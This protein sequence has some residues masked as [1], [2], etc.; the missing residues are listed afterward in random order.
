MCAFTVTSD[1]TPLYNCVSWALHCNDRVIWP[2]E[3][4]QWGWPPAVQRNETPQAFR[5]FFELMDFHVCQGSAFEQGFEKIAIYAK[6]G[7]VQHV[8]RQLRTGVWTSKMGAG[9]DGDHPTLD[10]LCPDFNEAIVALYMRRRDTGR[11]PALPPLHPPPPRLITPDG[12]PL[13]P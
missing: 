8:S 7:A 11:P 10:E 1:A 4:D 6:D 2:D 13:I 5:E 9:A 12:G 3:R